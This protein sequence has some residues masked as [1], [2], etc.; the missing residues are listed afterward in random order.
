MTARHFSDAGGTV[1]R[2]IGAILVL[3]GVAV[4]IFSCTMHAGNVASLDNVVAFV[5]QIIGLPFVIVGAILW[6][7]GG[8]L[9]RKFYKGF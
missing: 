9:K 4:L 2:V 7:I 3:F 1:L 6:A 5:A 8:K